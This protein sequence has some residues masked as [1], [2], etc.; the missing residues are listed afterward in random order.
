MRR[1]CD[2]Q[3]HLSKSDYN[4]IINMATS[5]II[6]CAIC[7][8]PALENIIITPCIHKF[9]NICITH[10]KEISNSCPV[11]RHD[12]NPSPPILVNANDNDNDNPNYPNPDPKTCLG[13]VFYLCVVIAQPVIP[14]SL[15]LVY[16]MTFPDVMHASINLQG[17]QSTIACLDMFDLSQIYNSLKIIIACHAAPYLL[18]I[19][20][21]C[22]KSLRYI[23]A[24][25][26]CIIIGALYAAHR[27]VQNG[28]KFNDEIISLC[29]KNYNT[30]HTHAPI[31]NPMG[32]SMYSYSETIETALAM[33]YIDSF[34]ALVMVLFFRL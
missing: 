15:M 24:I 3:A 23:S 6:T 19:F 31:V 20:A 16:G 29:F 4:N 1:H 8:E 13:G 2:L 18:Y 11:C 9:H 5:P 26:L 22:F 33:L 14:L 10:W 32:Y 30:N 27:G 28:D 12:M 25:R 7:L 17:I 34:V 21:W